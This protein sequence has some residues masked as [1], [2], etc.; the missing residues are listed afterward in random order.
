MLHV[1]LSSGYRHHLVTESSRY[2]YL[3]THISVLISRYSYPGTHIS[4]LISILIS[5]Y[6]Y[7]A[8]TTICSETS[9]PSSVTPHCCRIYTSQIS[10]TIAFQMLQIIQLS[11]YYSVIYTHTHTHREAHEFSKILEY[12]SKFYDPLQNSRSHLRIFC[13]TSKF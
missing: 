10:R 3:G 13:T 2:S 5:R 9:W 12:T 8:T 11:L 1:E 6:L 7:P 4:V